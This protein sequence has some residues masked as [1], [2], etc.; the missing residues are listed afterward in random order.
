MRKYVSFLN[1]LNEK[2]AVD[3]EA[4]EEFWIDRV[5]EFFAGKP[6][7]I[8]LDAS[9]SLRTVVRDVIGQ[10]QDRQKTVPGMYY[11]GAVM[12][13]LVGAKLD[14]ALGRG[15]FQHNSFSTADAPRDRAG[16]FFLGD[17]AIHVTTAPSEAVIERCRENLNNGHRPVLVTIQRGLT[18]AEGLAANV[19]LSDRIDFFEIEQFVAL[20]IYEIAKFAAEGR[21]TAVADVVTRYNEI[22]DE[23][24]TDPS[25]KIELRR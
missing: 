10:A 13:H 17:V 20:N 16:D 8:K 23:F 15:H 7:K 18:V 11:A 6:F 12:Q 4:V 14:C 19:G 9:R 24:E 1:K 22:V 21:R 25:L 3:L 5:H 2:G